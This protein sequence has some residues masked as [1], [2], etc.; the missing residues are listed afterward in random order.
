M[1]I[2]LHTNISNEYEHIDIQ[3]NSPSIT[4]ELSDIINFINNVAN[5][6]TNDILAQ[7]GTEFFLIDLSDIIYFYSEEKNN[8]CKTAKGNFKISEK[9]YELENFLPKDT[10]I[11]ISNAVIANVK[12]VKSFDTSL[13]S[14]IIVNFDDNSYEYVSKRRIS[15]IQKFLK[16]RR[17]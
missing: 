16:D 14:N 6:K 13:V 5:A 2:K 17:K 1:E 8:Y 10:F 9:L 3:I 4:P 15:Q 11:R 7:N 12:H